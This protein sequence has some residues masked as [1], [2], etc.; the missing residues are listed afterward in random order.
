MRFHFLPL[1][2]VLVSVASACFLL[3]GTPALASERV[4]LKYNVL[5]EPI[6]TKELSTFA[7]TGKLSTL[8]QV[9][10]LLAQQDPEIIRQYLTTPIKISPTDLDKVFNSEIGDTT[11]GELSQVL[12]TRSRQGDQQAL[13]SAF[14][15]SASQDQQI[16]LLEIIQNYPAAE[17][18]IEADRLETA[19]NQLRRLQASLP[20][21]LGSK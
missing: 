13:R 6:T 17:V 18:E 16:T 9:T 2:R 14:V 20:D 10:I 15:A 3:L 1:R 8:L 11:L 12:H 5:R 7:Q 4:M 21:I 19:N